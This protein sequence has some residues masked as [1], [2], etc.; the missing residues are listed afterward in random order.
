MYTCQR[1]LLLLFAVCIFVFSLTKL[2]SSADKS[3]PFSFA[4][5]FVR[6]PTHFLFSFLSVASGIRLDS[7]WEW[8]QSHILPR[9]KEK[10]RERKSNAMKQKWETTLNRVDSYRLNYPNR[11]L[12]II[13][14]AGF[15][16]VKFLYF[17]YS[18]ET[19]L[20]FDSWFQK[21][22]EKFI[23]QWEFIVTL[24]RFDFF[25]RSNFDR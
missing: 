14:L 18:T 22:I 17:H 7:K 25:N 10:K 21:F 19:S 4:S 20:Y 23:I 8:K 12:W 3:F 1:L 13:V 2:V 5:F 9:V 15:E 16:W 6:S 24:F 11:Q